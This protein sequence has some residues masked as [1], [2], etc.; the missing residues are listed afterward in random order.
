MQVVKNEISK[1]EY[2]KYK[3]IDI[4]ERNAVVRA[5]LPEYII[6]GYGYYGSFL[7]EENGKYYLCLNIGSS[8]D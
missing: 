8:C 3:E 1:E 6:F 7:T 2:N 4:S 5:T